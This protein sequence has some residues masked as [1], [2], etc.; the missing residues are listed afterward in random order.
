MWF[1]VHV[2]FL[3][4]IWF[5]GAV[6]FFFACT[7]NCGLLTSSL[8]CLGQRSSLWVNFVLYIDHVSINTGEGHSN[9]SVNE[10]QTW[11]I[12]YEAVIMTIQKH[13]EAKRCI[14]LSWPFFYEWDWAFEYAD[15]IAFIVTHWDTVLAWHFL[16]IWCM[17]VQF[18]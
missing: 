6:T 13:T 1:V 15:C 7:I 12:T 4:L 2:V 3:H 11:L 17:H 18:K 9:W 16:V 5:N 8:W 14:R 10:W